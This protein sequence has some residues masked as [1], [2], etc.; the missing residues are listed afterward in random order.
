[1]TQV[2]DSPE[3]T[4]PREIIRAVPFLPSK[5]GDCVATARM[6]F[7]EFLD[8]DHTGLAEW[9]DGEVHLYMSVTMAHQR[10][11]DFLNRLLGF[12][13]N[14]T[15]SGE[16]ITAPYAMAAVRGGPGRE[17]DITFIAA[18]HESL[19]TRSHLMGAPDLVVEVVSVDS[20]RRDRRVKRAEYEAAGIREY[21]IV[22]SREGHL[23][24]TQFLILVDG[25]YVEVA[26]VDG[27]YRS[28]AVPGFWLRTEWLAQER[29]NALA[30]F[31]E[32]EASFGNV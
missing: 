2:A 18:N 16:V 9:V 28:L 13:V 23:G 26:P 20:V 14:L 6:S 32:I 31:R 19:V 12:V 22:D 17:P 27:V 15:D 3:D 5:C 7:E 11:V 30:A 25:V 1:M 21:W 8:L 29:P 24:D 4:P 10:V